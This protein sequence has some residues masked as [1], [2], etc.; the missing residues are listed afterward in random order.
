M[1]MDRVMVA[2]CCGA[3]KSTLSIALADRLGLP[4]IHL[5]RLNWLDGWKVRPK[6]E[7]DKLH[8]AVIS[9]DRWLIDGN[10]GRTL[11]KRLERCDTV[12]YLDFPTIIC[13]SGIVGRV[14]KN[15]GKTRPDMGGNCPERFDW[16]FIKY[17]I[18]FRRTQGE[19]Q[20][21]LLASTR[22]K[23]IIILKNRR[24]VRKFLEGIEHV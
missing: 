1:A 7:F 3:G 4:L 12:I 16:E 2:G 15:H 13:L 24:Q 22:G 23:N 17:V 21:K 8:E 18:S 9:S 19:K 20:L 14:V 6:Q 10:Y 5:D 11:P